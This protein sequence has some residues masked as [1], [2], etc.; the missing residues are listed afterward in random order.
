MYTSH[1]TD[2]RWHADKRRI[3]GAYANL[4]LTVTPTC[5]SLE[6][7]VSTLRTQHH[8]TKITSRR[9]PD[10]YLDVD[11][12]G[13]VALATLGTG[14]DASL[15]VLAERAAHHAHV[16]LQDELVFGRTQH[17]LVVLVGVGLVVGAGAGAVSQRALR[18]L[19]N[20]AGYV[21]SYIGTTYRSPHLEMWSYCMKSMKIDV[22][23]LYEI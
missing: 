8:L 4:S 9:R 10:T 7:A 18:P 2:V 3:P 16:L 12:V 14:D 6:Q 20:A 23:V 21:G 22:V 5:L 17:H 15:H 1:H 13:V 19:S 11:A